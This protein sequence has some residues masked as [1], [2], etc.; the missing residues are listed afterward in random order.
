MIKILITDDQAEWRNYHVKS[1]KELF[2]NR[3][4]IDTAI[5]AWDGYEK[6]L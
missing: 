6:I 3:V 4:L 2:N 5:S 1:I